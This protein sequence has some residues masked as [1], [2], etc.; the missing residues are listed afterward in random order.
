MSHGRVCN[1]NV[2]EDMEALVSGKSQINN[3]VI[4]L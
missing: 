3:G 4:M 2:L 1:V